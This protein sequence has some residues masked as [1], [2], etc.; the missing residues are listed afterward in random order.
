MATA[1]FLPRQVLYFSWAS[2]HRPVAWSQSW[3][4]HIYACAV[5]GQT[6]LG[7]QVRKPSEAFLRLMREVTGI[8]EG[9]N[10]PL[11][12]MPNP[13]SHCR[14]TELQPPRH[15]APARLCWG[16]GGGAVRGIKAG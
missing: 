12:V 15:T 10:A 13:C 14:A 1:P 16:M 6:E 2:S 7:R 8:E 5:S 4:R 9:A 3:S 11:G